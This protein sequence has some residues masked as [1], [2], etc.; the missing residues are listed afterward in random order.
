M[1]KI[2]CIC[3]AVVLTAFLAACA[4]ADA[5]VQA[6][7]NTRYSSGIRLHPAA[8]AKEFTDREKQYVLPDGYIYAYYPVADS[9]PVFET[10]A[11]SGGYFYAN[12]RNPAGDF[13]EHEACSSKRTSVIAVTPGDIIHYQGYG[14]KYVPSVIWLDADEQYLYD[15]FYDSSENPVAITVPENAAFVWFGSFLYTSNPDSVVLKLSWEKC[16]ACTVTEQ[17]ANTGLI[18][19]YQESPITTQDYVEA[20][21]LLRGRKIVFDGDSIC[22]KHSA[23][24]GAYPAI[25]SQ[26]TGCRYENHAIGG[27][28][29]CAH[30]DRHSV[31]NNLE[32]LPKDGDLYCFEGGINDFFSST[33]IGTCSDGTPDPSTI[34][35]AMETI[36]RY[37]Q[38]NFP[39]KPV[40][41]VITHE[42]KNT[43]T[44]AN[45][46]GDTF[47]DYRD[48][49][50]QV[51]QK[52]GV[53]YYDAF[54]ESGLHG[55]DDRLNSK[56]L[57]ASDDRTPDGTHPNED[58]YRGYY[59]APLLNLFRE[60]ML[61]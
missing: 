49:M 28:R 57:T 32:N 5:P 58:G 21:D 9:F 11:R 26:I 34:C 41:F 4:K 40:C 48:A 53:P 12:S 22:A 13:T 55:W 24:G 56:Y 15:E 14:T 20:C 43:G 45:A 17:W 54:T 52:Y 60:A 1:K 31:V 8:S 3:F 19:T 61:K 30:N 16:Q 59:I 10:E 44:V 47:R 36:F 38:D 42:V 35:G 6:P 29:L 27:A 25:L 39:G 37:C 23:N 46:N 51:C 2:S 18:S 50:V 7:A 33:P